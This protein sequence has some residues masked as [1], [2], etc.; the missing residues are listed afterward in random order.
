MYKIEIETTGSW[1]EANRKEIEATTKRAM[2]KVMNNAI[3]LTFDN[4]VK[5]TPIGVTRM[6]RN[7]LWRDVKETKNYVLGQIEVGKTNAAYKYAKAV[8]YGRVSKKWPPKGSLLAWMILKLGMSMKTALR[9]EFL[10]RRAIAKHGT[11]SV[12]MFTLG[13]YSSRDQV[14]RT[15][16]QLGRIIEETVPNVRK[17]YKK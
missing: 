5:N 9:R 1:A 4:V 16:N 10:L 8:E 17:H 13:Y 15:F 14:M 7:A 12:L 2:L 6:L 11:K 3:N